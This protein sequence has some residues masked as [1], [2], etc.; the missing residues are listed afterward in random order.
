MRQVLESHVE[1]HLR[2]LASALAEELAGSLKAAAYEPF[3]RCELADFLEISCAE[4]RRRALRLRRST[5]VA[6]QKG[7]ARQGGS[8]GN[9]TKFSL[10]RGVAGSSRR[11]MVR[12]YSFR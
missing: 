3:L 12:K 9:F 1:A 7:C 4:S 5:A 2:H 8:D 6:T 11:F 10:S